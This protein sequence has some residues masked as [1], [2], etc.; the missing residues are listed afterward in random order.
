MSQKSAILAA[1]YAG[2]R[3]TVLTMLARFHTTAGQQR[4]NEWRRA[5]VPIKDEWTKLS[6]GKRIKTYFIEPLDKQESAGL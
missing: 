5:G 4:V 3:L 1:L 2:E 6:S